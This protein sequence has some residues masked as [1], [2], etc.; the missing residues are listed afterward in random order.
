MFFIIYTYAL[1]YFFTSYMEVGN[2]FF[3]GRI[4]LKQENI[5]EKL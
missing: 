1:I 2:T 3:Y 5:F 4:S